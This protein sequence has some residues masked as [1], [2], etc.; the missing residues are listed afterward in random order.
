[1]LT[2]FVVV[3][4]VVTIVGFEYIFPLRVIMFKGS[5]FLKSDLTTG[6]L[7]GGFLL[8]VRGGLLNLLLVCGVVR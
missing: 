4:V 2:G 8:K 7:A 1:V 5:L 3:V 6:E